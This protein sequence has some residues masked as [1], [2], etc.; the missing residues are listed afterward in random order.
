VNRRIRAFFD[1]RAGNWDAHMCPEHPDRLARIVAGL[2]LAPGSRVL[3]VGAGNG[4]LLPLLRPAA[5]LAVALDISARM[6]VEARK[7]VDFAQA[8]YA[9]AD[10]LALP[11]RSGCLDVVI[12][13]SCFPHF[14]DQRRA[15]DEMARVLRTGGRLVIC[16]TRS[17]QAINECH[18][19]H[20]GVIGG[21]E[22]PDADGMRAFLAGAGLRVGRLEDAPD[23]YVLV[24]EKPA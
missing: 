12:C 23:R 24:A 8:A 11:L 18:H 7:R 10:V 20:G 22:L 13:N 6:L 2:G 9:Q 4:V 17:R 3:D 5:A 19:S 1:E 15:T 21:H 14:H 16:H